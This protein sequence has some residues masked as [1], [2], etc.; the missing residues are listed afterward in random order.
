MPF[1]IAIRIHTC[2]ICTLLLQKFD[3]STGAPTAQKALGGESLIESFENCALA[4]E[5]YMSDIRR[6]APAVEKRFFV[7]A[8][9][10]DLAR[11]L[12]KFLDELVYL[13]SAENFI[14]C[15]VTIVKLE[16]WPHEPERMALL[17]AHMYACFFIVLFDILV[18]EIILMHPS[19]QLEPKSKPLHIQ[20]CR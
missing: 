4:V 3:F 14:V 15:K 7:T 13:H 2:K 11:L 5:N 20:I 8:A 16:F 9:S 1:L 17:E 6:I 12:Y 10:A 18:L 19:I